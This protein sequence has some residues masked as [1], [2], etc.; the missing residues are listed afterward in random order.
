MT[1]RHHSII[2]KTFIIALLAMGL[3]TGN[4]AFA[5]SLEEAKSQ[6]FLGEMVSG[7]LGLV[8]PTAPPEM[9]ALMNEVNQKRKAKYQEVAKR[10]NTTLKA[11]ETLAGK[12]ALSKTSPGHY[13]QLPNGQWQKK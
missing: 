10:N 9:K 1:Q 7:Y 8:T 11:V 12:T 5:A 4:T 2:G 13:I 6:G 3:Y